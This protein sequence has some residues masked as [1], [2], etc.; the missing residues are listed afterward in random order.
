MSIRDQWA[1]W[2]LHRR[3]AGEDRRSTLDYLGA[4]RDTVLDNAA[5]LS[6]ET[7]LD[8]GC[9]DG[10]IGFGALDRGVGQVAFTD[11]SGDLLDTCRDAASGLEVADR[12]R[13][14]LAAA[15][16]LA[17]IEDR[18]VDV[19]T[20]RSVLIYVTN[21]QQ[22]FDEF[23][24]V[25]RHGG[26]VSL[27]EPINSFRLPLPPGCLGAYHLPGLE[28]LVASVRA[29]YERIQP[30]D[31]DPMLDFDERD[32]VDFAERAGFASVRLQLGIEVKPLGP[33][34]WDSYLRSVPN[35]K[36]PSIG[37]VIDQALNP[38]ERAELHA[39]LRPLVEQGSGRSRNATA[40]LQ[41]TKA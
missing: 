4:I 41:A 23:H 6:G 5:L 2:L 33:R 38:T 16:D 35:P 11:I 22:A 26:R 10:L 32:L 24:R 29:E 3:F 36:L 21:K 20:T 19:V 17:C 7:L 39:R 28:S 1:E 8:V 13:F 30:P 37:A 18:S 31:S 40:Y 27:F 14:D 25:L 15:D 9:G 12:C 34:S